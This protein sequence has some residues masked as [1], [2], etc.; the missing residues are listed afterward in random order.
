MSARDS[1]ITGHSILIGFVCV[2]FCLTIF[3]NIY[4]RRE[5]ARRD[6]LS[7]ERGQSISEGERAI[8]EM[9]LADSASW[10]RYTV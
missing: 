7:R 4:L 9:E 1:F 6:A 3:M 2:A 5:N 10:F 8:E